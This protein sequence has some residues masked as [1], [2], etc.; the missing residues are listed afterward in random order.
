M[1]S[2]EIENELTVGE[3]QSGEAKPAS[4]KKNT[5]LQKGQNVQ[6]RKN[7]VQNILHINRNMM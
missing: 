4:K 7:E 2:R 3:K 1:T 6:V 5:E